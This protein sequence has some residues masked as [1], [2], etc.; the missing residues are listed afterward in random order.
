VRQIVGVLLDPELTPAGRWR[1]LQALLR[2]ITYQQQQAEKARR[3][4]RK[5]RC[6]KLRELGI[7][8]SKLR[9]CFNLF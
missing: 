6:R 1:K 9:K 4:H 3:S 8:I 5:A 7:W 2:R